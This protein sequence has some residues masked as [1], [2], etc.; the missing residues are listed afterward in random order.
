MTPEI[1]HLGAENC[2]T[3]SCHLVQTK[4]G[5]DILVDCGK[6]YGHDLELAF[7]R[8]PV[9]PRDI[10]YLFLT[11]A[12]IDHIGRVPDLIDAGFQG[13][14]IC[15]HGTK[16]LLIPMLHDALSFTDRSGK[17]VQRLEKAIDE[18]SWGFEYNEVFSLKKGINFK[19]GNAGHILGSCFIRFS[20]PQKPAGDYTVIFSGD[21]GC[22][23]TPIL[24]DPDQPDS[25]DLLVLE[26][27]YGNR[28]HT[29]R[30]NRGN[31]SPD[32]KHLTG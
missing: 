14:I 10:D 29:G 23:D 25:C 24:P 32:E 16:A 20:F 28:N 27:T 9:L 11:H 15:T 19:L 26:S 31:S 21:L 5:V 4:V 18:L 1:K 22:T 12:H 2:V 17:Q 6:A 30:K 3:G 13:E 8:F 7:D